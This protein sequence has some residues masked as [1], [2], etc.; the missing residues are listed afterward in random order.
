M[1]N[2]D[3]T[4]IGPISPRKGSRKTSVMYC[5]LRAAKKVCPK[6]LYLLVEMMLM[7]VDLWRRLLSVLNRDRETVIKASR[8]IF[9][10][11]P[12]SLKVRPDTDLIAVCKLYQSP[13]VRRLTDPNP[14]YININMPY[15]ISL[16]IHIRSPLEEPH[17][18]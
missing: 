9:S 17:L 12:K 13:C 10:G 1:V 3:I 15:S 14:N 8:R 5:S 4:I 2:Y 7:I 18:G 6:K 16:Q 11:T